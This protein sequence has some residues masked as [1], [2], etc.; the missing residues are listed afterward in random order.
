MKR[1]YF[2]N[3]VRPL[4]AAGLWVLGT[5][6][7]RAD[8]VEDLVKLLPEGA[9]IFFCIKDTPELVK[10]WDASGVGRFIQDE[11]VKRWMAPLY[12]DGVPAWDR[13]IQEQ[14]GT[15]LR[16]GLEIYGGSVVVS[17]VISDLDDF[18]DSKPRLLVLSEV[19]GKEAEI[20]ASKVKQL[21]AYRKGK[22]P[23]AV[24]TTEDFEGVSVQVFKSKEGE[25]AEWIE[26]WV[27][28]EGIL[29]EVTD[30][31]LVAGML[32]RLKGGEAP[33]AAAVRM[34]RL[35]ELRGGTADITVYG[36]LEFLLGKL[37]AKFEAEAANNPGVPFTPKQV[38]DALGANEL[39]GLA[40]CIDLTEAHSRADVVLLHDEKPEG[41]LPALLRGTTTEVP[42]LAFIPTGMDT[43]S[44]SRV[45]LV[46][47]YDAV[48]RAIGKMG[49]MA[50]MV[51]SQITG[52]EQQAGMNIRNDLLGSLDD[53][54]VVAGTMTLKPGTIFPE[55]NQVTGFKLKNRDRFQSAFDSLWNMIGKGFGVFEETEYEGYKI[56]MMK[57]SLSG[58]T[59]PGGVPEQ[60]IGYVI[61][62][63]YVFMVQGAPELA[64]KIL[65][66][67]KSS[68]PGTSFWDEPK[69]QEA[70][71]ALPR[72]YTGMGVSNGSSILRTVLG[73]LS[74]AAAGPLKGVTTAPK[75]GGPKGRA[76]GGDADDKKS[77]G[78]FDPEATPEDEV[79]DRYFG[80]GATGMYSH[81]DASHM[82]YIAQPPK[83]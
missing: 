41:L 78:W 6:S 2:L 43:A 72:G 7:A 55:Q 13:S 45:S 38:F 44:V 33:H 50:A 58:G 5:I 20:E 40:G 24:R 17:A 42:Q 48:L 37:L 19:A 47:I 8:K 67:L 14:S 59:Q 22:H 60:R 46:S 76:S 80:M 18:E 27:I 16:E 3:A 4:V 56:R 1:S 81:P 62:E 12:E 26:G 73:M 49:P 31:S 36:D 74:G 51:T 52:M 57:S 10:D 39:R 35:A 68:P 65:A 70:L 32:A 11:A 71:A 83:P 23:E 15:T 30:R 61:T 69:V 54:Y 64:H 29:M 34:N 28:A 21:E 25:G 79:F 63:D 66:R 9:C 75:G 53:V 82:L 77:E